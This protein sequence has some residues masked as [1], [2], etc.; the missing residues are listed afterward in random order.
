MV[1]PAAYD[2]ALM[3]LESHVDYERLA[4]GRRESPTL[5]PIADTLALFADPH[6]DYPIVHVTGTNGKGTTT[7]LTS[8]LLSATG[9]RVGTFTSPDLHAINERIALNGQAIDDDDFTSLMGRLYDAEKVSGIVLTRFEL[10]T[11]G[12]LLNFS[13]EGVD[14]A[15][16]EVGLGGTWD[17]TNV[18]DGVVTVLTNVDLDHTAVLGDSVGEIAR[19]KVGIFRPQAVAVVSTTNAI[20]VEIATSRARE[21]GATLWTI[22]DSFALERNELAVGG[23]AITVRSPYASY[24]DVLVTLHGIHQGVNATTAI[25]AAE[26]FLGRALG[27]DVV[28]G[29][30]ASA[31]MPG[32]MELLS[33]HPTIVVDGAH[34]PAGMRAF[35]AALDGAFHVLGERRCVLGMLT[36]RDVDDMAAPLVSLGFTEFHCCAPHSPRA[37]EA[38][39]VAEA[40]RRAGGVAFEHASVSTALAYAREHSGDDDLIVAVGSLYLVA[41]VRA[42]V[43]HVVTRHPHQHW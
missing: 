18:V 38:R 7:T 10:L 11:V 28:R 27:E 42:D 34:N 21:L 16:I 4:P 33:R 2:D 12:A 8:A 36:G 23:R 43:L 13:D 1:R 37:M 30:F 22:E 20:V 31:R 19:D 17:S 6:R 14:V 29:T 15:V 9:L 40:V 25:V 3:W 39:L 5:Q 35:C 26:A 41:Q 32:R 24:D